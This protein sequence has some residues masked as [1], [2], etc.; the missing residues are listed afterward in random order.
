VLVTASLVREDRGQPLYTITQVQDISER[1]ERGAHLAYQVDHD[2]LTDLSNR[3][4]FE[5]ELARET[6]RVSRYGSGGAL[7]LIDLD[8]FK[9][10]N[11]SLGHKAGD[12]LLKGVAMA[13][14]RR[15]RQTDILARVGGDEFAVLLPQTGTEEARV[16]AAGIVDAVRRQVGEGAIHVTA[17]VG[18][19]LFEGL[20]PEE[21]RARADVAMYDAKAAGGGRFAMYRA[22][23]P[24]KDEGD[25]MSTIDVNAGRRWVERRFEEI[26]REYG[27]PRRLAREDRWREH[28]APLVTQ[29]QSMTYYIEIGGRLK[30]GEIEFSE[31]DLQIAGAGEP[32][33]EE[34]LGR[35]IREV[36]G[37]HPVGRE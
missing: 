28:R 1:K 5:Q 20:D 22:K 36:L 37:S 29:N 9:R 32:S 21:L 7:L 11:D 4:L 6:R 31:A 3:R 35:H 23:T 13:L 8:H 16:V 24:D 15:M 2:F 18:V 17:S 27:A 34:R 30:R 19:A 25:A 14:K 12:D 26:A 33:T 10:V